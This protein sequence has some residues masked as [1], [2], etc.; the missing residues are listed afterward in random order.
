M[1]QK[2]D[3]LPFVNERN[4][5]LLLLAMHTAGAIG[6]SIEESRNLFQFLTP[7]NLVATAAILLHFEKHKNTSYF[8]FILITF[9]LGYGVEVIGVATGWP[10]GTYAYGE[11]LGFQLF[12]VPLAIG[13]N[14]VIL[15]YCSGHLAKKIFRNSWNRII[16]AALIM[17]MLDIMIEPVAIGYDFWNW[18]ELSVPPSNYMG[19]FAVSAVLQIIF[20]RVVKDSNNSL[21]IRLLYIQ[22]GFFTLLNLI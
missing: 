16:S 19:W 21:A 6:L 20:Q 10:F 22:I 2:I 9:L 13:L 14:W 5:F 12:E 17:T 8:I 3:A 1:L 18:A 7:F 15:V 11:T 4:A